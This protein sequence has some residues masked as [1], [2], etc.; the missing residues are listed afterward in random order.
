[1]HHS[2]T[3]ICPAHASR[4]AYVHTCFAT[5][6]CILMIMR[7]HAPQCKLKYTLPISSSYP[8]RPPAAQVLLQWTH[9]HY[10]PL[11]ESSYS[12]L[13]LIGNHYIND[14]AHLRM[15]VYVVGSVSVSILQVCGVP[16]A[17][18]YIIRNC[19]M[20]HRLI[21]HPGSYDMNSYVSWSQ[22]ASYMYK[23]N[24]HVCSLRQNGERV[25]E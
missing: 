2:A 8:A 19:P 3:I 20:C 7:T 9:V 24:V 16:Y 15:Y 21:Y 4:P 11:C 13:V 10:V 5:V 22:L 23:I 6:Q 1:M 17:C 14:H 18:F 12:L 25:R